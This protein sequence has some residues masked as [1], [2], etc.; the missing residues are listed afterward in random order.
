MA[1]GPHFATSEA[2]VA[3]LPDVVAAL[4]SWRRRRWALGRRRRLMRWEYWPLWAVYAPVFLQGLW[5]ALR[6]R[7]LTV[8]TATNPGMPAASGLVGQSKADILRGLAGAGERVA[9]WTLLAPGLASERRVALDAWREEQQLEYPIVLKPDR[10]E[11]G[12]GVVIARSDAEVEAAF[13]FTPGPLL[14]QAYVPGLEWGVFYIREP[15]QAEGEIFAVTE[16]RNLHVV[17]DGRTELGDLVLADERAVNQAPVFRE[18]L[19]ARWTEKPAAGERVQLGELGTHCRGALF[20]EGMGR[21]TARL[22]AEIDRVSRSYDGFYFGRYDVRA[23]SAEALQHGDFTIIELNGV[24][25]EA[26]S[27]YDPQ[28]S[29]WHGWRVLCRQWRC[30]CAIGAAN[31]RRGARVWTLGEIRALLREHGTS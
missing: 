9:N 6:Y 14:A 31:R 4:T 21:V 3:P 28:Y 27:I 19:G 2:P 1:T 24:T 18:L 5:L 17:G 20:L 12:A 22:S 16:K 11:R 26:T 23:A 10:G 25:S 7:S 8:F 13:A 30:A 15:G 29:V